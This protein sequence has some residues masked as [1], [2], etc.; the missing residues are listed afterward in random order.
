[1]TNG[2]FVN[3]PN[4]SD[5]SVLYFEYVLS[6]EWIYTFNLDGRWKHFIRYRN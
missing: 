1:M 6:F 2:S 3:K 4:L 5:A